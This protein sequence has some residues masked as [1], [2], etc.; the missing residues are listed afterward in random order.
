MV[1]MKNTQFQM[2]SFLAADCDELAMLLFQKVAGGRYDQRFWKSD[3]QFDCSCFL[4]IQSKPSG[5]QKMIQST[6]KYVAIALLLGASGAQA[7]SVSEREYKRGFNDCLRGDYDQN[8]HGASYK[9]GCRAAENSG[10]TT[11]DSIK[12]QAN[13]AGMKLA[14]RAALIGHFYPQTRSVRV[15]SSDHTGAGWTLYGE[16]VLDDGS[17]SQFACIFSSSGHF[18]HLNASSPQGGNHEMDS[19][20]Y[21]PQNVSEANRYQYPGCN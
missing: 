11:G 12:S 19:E 13:P 4:H 2:R 8:Q 20:G 10:K 16:A 3:R 1:L 7:A 17:S 18:K 15:D 14:C 5:V 9:R 6:L 21:C